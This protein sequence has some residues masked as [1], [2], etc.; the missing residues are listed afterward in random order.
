MED[1]EFRAERVR[2]RNGNRIQGSLR[3]VVLKK[4]RK[5]EGKKADYEL[6]KLLLNTTR[7]SSLPLSIE[8][9]ETLFFLGVFFVVEKQIIFRIIEFDDLVQDEWICPGNKSEKRGWFQLSF[10]LPLSTN[11]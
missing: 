8:T 3:R 9:E 4:K 11:F 1:T 5:K 6:W 7:S 2:S 10:L